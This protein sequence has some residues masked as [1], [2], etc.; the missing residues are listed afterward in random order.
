MPTITAFESVTLDGVMQGPG[1][2]DEDT[3]SGF[4][5]GGWFNGYQDDVLMKYAGEGMAE[6]PGLLFG[7]RTYTDVLGYWSSIGPNPFVDSLLGSDKFVVSRSADSELA[8]PNSQLLAGDAVDTV[9]AL[10]ERYS[11]GLLIMGSG[12]LVR[13]LHTAGLIDRYVLQVYPILL[14][15]GTKLFG[16]GDRVDLTLE[17]SIPTTTGVLIAEYTVNR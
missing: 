7:H 10:K 6:A 4:A 12:E 3:R 8:Y 14:G 5:Y 9:A 13:T 17:R 16:P 1:R 15:S 11:R 2:A